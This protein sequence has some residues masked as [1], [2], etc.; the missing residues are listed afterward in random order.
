M[1]RND[2]VDRCP[3]FYGLFW[4]KFRRR[5]KRWALVVCRPVRTAE[6]GAFGCFGCHR[7]PHVGRSGL[8]GLWEAGGCDVLPGTSATIKFARSS[9]HV[10][11]PICCFPSPV[12]Y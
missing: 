2:L 6:G 4:A 1:R 10:Y 8:T 3:P 9:Y 7:M 11:M 12:D 5:E